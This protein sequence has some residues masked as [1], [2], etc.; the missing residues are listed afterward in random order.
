MLIAILGLPQA[1]KATLVQHLVQEHAFTHVVISTQPPPVSS[2]TPAL[3][4][5][6]SSAFLDYATRNWR[7]DYVTTHLRN[8][9]KLV[10]FA[11]R[12]FVV[13]VGVEAPLRVRWKRA[14]QR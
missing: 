1:G 2:S 10:E 4:F 14:C 5:R 9:L 12:P 3:H 8:K 7:E 6:T 11:K 13:I